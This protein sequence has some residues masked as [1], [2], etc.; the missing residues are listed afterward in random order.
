RER[1]LSDLHP[2]PTRRSSDLRVDPHTVT[3]ASQP[4]GPAGTPGPVVLVPRG[5]AWGTRVCDRLDAWGA[6]G[7]VLPLIRTELVRTEQ[8][9]R[10]RKSTRLNSSHVSISYAV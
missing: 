7:W 6:R 2:F 5:G 1:V 10:D 9:E 3:A 4:A 8:L